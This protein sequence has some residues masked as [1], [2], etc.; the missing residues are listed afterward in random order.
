MARHAVGPEFV[1]NKADQALGFYVLGN[2][3]IGT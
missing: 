1:I 2:K 3:V